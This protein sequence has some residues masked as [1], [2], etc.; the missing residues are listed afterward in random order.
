M[1]TERLDRLDEYLWPQGFTSDAWMLVDAARD[2]RIYGM[3]LECFY[4]RHNCL[5]SGSLAPNIQV[6]A[7]YL[8]HLEYDDP[9]TKRFIRYAW[10]NSWGVFLKCDNQLQT[11]RHH[12]RTLL[13]ARDEQGNRLMFRYYD[14]RV[15]RAYLP[16]CTADELQTV[17]G[18]INCFLVEG[19]TADTLIEFYL[20]RRALITAR[21]SLTQA[22]TNAVEGI[23]GYNVT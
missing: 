23:S 4:S 19:Q 13:T 10:G 8:I 20:E 2:K 22:S 7:P 18:P 15:L 12:L 21:Q 9:R 17:F 16:T 14:P 5:F 1:T 6:V 3:L 11:L